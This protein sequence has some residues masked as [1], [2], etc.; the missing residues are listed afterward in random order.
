MCDN[1][2]IGKIST[3]KHKGKG[4]GK[5]TE[6]RAIWSLFP[7][8]KTAFT[9]EVCLLTDTVIKLVLND[10]INPHRRTKQNEQ[11]ILDV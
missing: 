7:Q 5:S 3:N 1:R 6:G 4:F 9:Y 11:Q 8:W 2:T 10:V